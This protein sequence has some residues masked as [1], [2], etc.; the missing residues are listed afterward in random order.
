MNRM[1]SCCIAL[2]LCVLACAGEPGK[3]AGPNAGM[4]LRERLRQSLSVNFADVP[5]ME[6]ITTLQVISGVRIG[7]EPQAE[8]VADKARIT[9]KM[10]NRPL[11]EVLGGISKLTG[12]N[13]DLHGDRIAFDLR[14]GHGGR[15]V[16][17][18]G[19]VRVKFPDG[20]EIEADGLGLQNAPR[21]TAQIMDRLAVSD[22][23]LVYKNSKDVPAE[24]L[25]EV[26]RLMAPNAKTDWN[27]EL[28][29]ITIRGDEPDLRRIAAAVRALRYDN[30]PA[31]MMAPPPPPRR[32]M[33]VPLGADRVETRR[34][35]APPRPGEPAREAPQPVDGAA[36]E[37]AR[38][39]LRENK[40]DEAARERMKLERTDRPRENKVPEREFEF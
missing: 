22:G 2:G 7:I 27:D 32:P 36:R 34:F 4:E 13:F 35:V 17:P 33:G 5:L 40:I 31:A 9:L 24:K 1:L 14:E 20:T 6:A 16:P 37:A 18:G 39:G 30:A 15:D 8:G 21:L 11:E 19:R 29:L 25:K 38:A 12:L 26:A 10:D 3:D 28:Q 23:V